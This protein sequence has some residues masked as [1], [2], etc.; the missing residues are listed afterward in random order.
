MKY[1]NWMNT[2]TYNVSIGNDVILK[3]NRKLKSLQKTGL[4]VEV[5]VHQTRQIV[6]DLFDNIFLYFFSCFNLTKIPLYL[7]KISV[8]YKVYHLCYMQE[9]FPLHVTQATT[10]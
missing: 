7:G 3:P 4:F 10:S 5:S 1:S 9:I 6:F 2:Y 8:I